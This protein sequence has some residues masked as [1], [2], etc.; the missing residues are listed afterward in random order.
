MSARFT[1][2]S[3]AG[4]IGTLGHVVDGGYFENSGAVAAAE[5]V[6]LIAR[7][8][9]KRLVPVVILIDYENCGPQQKKPPADCN[10]TGDGPFPSLT[11]PAEPQAAERWANEVLSPV[12][13]LL[14][15]RGARGRQAVGDVRT[16]SQFGVLPN[17]VVEFRLVQR[18]V[19]M[20]LGWVLSY[21]ARKAIDGGVESRGN[22]WARN[23][24]AQWL[25]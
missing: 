18:D 9:D 2:V 19:S 20:P 1:Y 23:T 10:F 6:L 8:P 14:A 15:T 5:L 3:P 17:T 12:R 24:I 7:H 21:Q 25:R 11:Q 4:R 22:L 16:A 13:A